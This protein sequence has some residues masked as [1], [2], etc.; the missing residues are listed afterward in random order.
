LTL[1]VK[2]VEKNPKEI[3]A[4]LATEPYCHLMLGEKE[5]AQLL[6]NAEHL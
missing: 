3:P 4:T 2:I 5:V 1:P 6:A